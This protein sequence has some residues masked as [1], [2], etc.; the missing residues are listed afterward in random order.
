MQVLYKVLSYR[1]YRRFICNSINF[2][3]RKIYKEFTKILEYLRNILKLWINIA[4]RD[5]IFTCILQKFFWSFF[6][7]YNIWLISC[8]SRSLSP[9]V[10]SCGSCWRCIRSWTTLRYHR[11]SCRYISIGRGSDWGSSEPYDWWRSLTSSSTLTF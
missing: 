4:L 8:D 1:K 2:L 3:K 9:P 7:K 11:P 10:T 6:V 5:I